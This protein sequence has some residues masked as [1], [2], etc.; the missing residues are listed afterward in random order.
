MNRRQ[1]PIVAIIGCLIALP[2]F[3]EAYK[4][5]LPGGA[6]EISSTPCAKGSSTL[7]V[8]ATE[9]ISEQSRRDAERLVEQMRK[10]AER[11][12]A[13]RLA[14]QPAR[15]DETTSQGV[16]PATPP[17]DDVV[18]SCLRNLE[19]MAVDPARRAELESG[20][21]LRGLSGEPASI[22]TPN[23][24]APLNARPLPPRPVVSPP[25]I[26][27]QVTPGSSPERI[28]QPLVTPAKRGSNALFSAPE[29][30]APR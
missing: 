13:A 5:Q 11:L 23:Y 17:R 16:P 9:N 2:T 14:E 18:Q 7:K 12:E 6:T 3:A 4:C 1:K 10:D 8:I 22:P 24:N 15:R 29:S 20:C 27:P 26:L 19:R 25:P 21:R 28:S 30:S